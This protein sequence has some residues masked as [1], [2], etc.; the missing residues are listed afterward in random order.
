MFCFR[1]GRKIVLFLSGVG[2]VLSEVPLGVY[3]IL[4]KYEIDVDA[5]SF[6]P[7]MTLTFFILFFNLGFGPIPWVMLSELFSSNVKSLAT[8]LV[9]TFVWILSFIVTK[10]F[11]KA[12]KIFGLGELFLFFAFCSIFASIFSVLYV[13][14]TK[15]RTFPE[16]QEQLMR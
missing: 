1:W 15:G 2:M 12:V 7:I 3:C 11:E 6:L 5:I 10:Y 4:K 13:I 14:E 8:A 9:S 16:I